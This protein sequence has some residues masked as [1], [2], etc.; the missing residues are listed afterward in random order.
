MTLLP[1]VPWTARNWH[2]F[3]RFQ[4]LA[5]R[6][7]TDPGE[8]NPYGFQRW[9]RTWAIEFASTE[10]VYWNYGGGSIE[11]G[12]L[13]SRAFDS[14][15]QYAATRALLTDYNDSDNAT[16]ALDIRFSAIAAERI[17]TH[18]LRY[19]VVL[20]VARV[21]NMMLRPRTEMLPV[22]LEWWK[23]QDHRGADLFALFYAAVNLGFFVLAGIALRRRDWNPAQRA[24]VA[25]MLASVVLRSALLLTLDN[26][27]ARYTLEFY[28]VL[29]VLA[30]SVVSGRASHTSSMASVRNP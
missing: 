19:Y 6:F 15:A 9:Y 1:L 2:T 17:R 13:P 10:N 5:P 25:A 22:P 23:F 7:A 3:H 16:P 20:P 26:S 18:P 8:F 24:V 12:D 4:P 11:P 14:D 30:S 21:I 29:L 28:P 27:E